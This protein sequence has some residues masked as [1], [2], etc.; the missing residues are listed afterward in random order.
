MNDDGCEEADVELDEGKAL[1]GTSDASELDELSSELIS[2]KS[3]VGLGEV[4]AA[5][6]VVGTV[7]AAVVGV[8]KPLL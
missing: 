7:V 4:I 8:Y 3:V 1:A 2:D 6:G 5:G